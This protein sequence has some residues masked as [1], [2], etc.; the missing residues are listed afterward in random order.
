[1]S[2]LSSKLQK[3]LNEQHK[4]VDGHLAATLEKDLGRP[5]TPAD[6]VKYCCMV[7]FVDLRL[8]IYYKDKLIAVVFPPIFYEQ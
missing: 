1:M 6:V 2:G 4:Q 5:A 3:A 8:A 7:R